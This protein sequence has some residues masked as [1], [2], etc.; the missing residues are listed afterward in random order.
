MKKFYIFLILV[1][2][3]SIF[4][5]AC[6]Q[7]RQKDGSTKA[8][9]MGSDLYINTSGECQQI[10]DGST[11][12]GAG[13]SCSASNTEC[14]YPLSCINEICEEPTTC[15]DKT[16]IPPIIGSGL[17]LNQDETKTFAEINLTKPFNPDSAIIRYTE[18]N[19]EPN[20]ESSDVFSSK[21]HHTENVTIK[22][23]VC[24]EECETDIKT[25]SIKIIDPPT[26]IQTKEDDNLY[27][28]DDKITIT[29]PTGFETYH[30]YYKLSDGTSSFEQHEDIARSDTS[31]EP[32]INMLIITDGCPVSTYSE[33]TNPISVMIGEEMA[34]KISVV[35]CGGGG[36]SPKKY[37]TIKT[38]NAE[39]IDDPI[40]DEVKE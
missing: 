4:L 22:A 20:C 29:K 8:S 35:M 32:P 19:S 15:G 5:T 13:E 36:S 34:T 7:R 17:T 28:S 9:C 2:T 39:I 10:G 40:D 18:D 27:S 25:Q 3:S 12:V 14:R 33:Y 23:L 38:V 6:R 24:Y 1:F 37:L 30:I 26:M 21:L 16:L 31:A 11:L